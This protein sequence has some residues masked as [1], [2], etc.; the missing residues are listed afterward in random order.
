ML[1]FFCFYILPIHGYVSVTTY[2][3]QFFIISCNSLN[4]ICVT[5]IHSFYW[6]MECFK[7]LSKLLYYLLFVLL[8]LE[9]SFKMFKCYY[10]DY[11]R[12]LYVCFI[13]LIFVLSLRVKDYYNVTVYASLAM[14]WLFVLDVLIRP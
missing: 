3:F 10:D 5:T 12:L 6:F 11:M 2:F 9:W 8:W 14:K 7:V 13:S 4:I 1:F